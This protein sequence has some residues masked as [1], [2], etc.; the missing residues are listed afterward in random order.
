MAHIFCAILILQC[1]FANESN[2]EIVDE[3]G[4]RAGEE[5]FCGTRVYF[6]RDRAPRDPGSFRFD[7]AFFRSRSAGNDGL[8]PVMTVLVGCTHDALDVGIGID[9]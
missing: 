1:S 4:I 9:V 7:E 8:T 2:G 3:P 5:K 6:Q